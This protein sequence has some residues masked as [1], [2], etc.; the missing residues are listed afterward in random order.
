[1]SRLL[2]KALGALTTD[3][4]TGEA[5]SATD[6]ISLGMGLAVAMPLIMVMIILSLGLGAGQ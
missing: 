3:P 2:N 5:L 1:M 4:A 6:L